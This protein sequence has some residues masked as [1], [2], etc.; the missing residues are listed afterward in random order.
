MPNVRAETSENPERRLV[1]LLCVD[2][3][4]LIFLAPEKI[5]AIFVDGWLWHPQDGLCEIDH[6][7]YR[8]KFNVPLMGFG[9]KALVA[10]AQR[11]PK[12]MQQSSS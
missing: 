8:I 9:V 1:D 6:D 2:R 10:E 11:F 7:E 3:D 4:Q 12:A 5:E